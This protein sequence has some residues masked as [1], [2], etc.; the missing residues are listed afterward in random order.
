MAQTLIF[1]T[2][3]SKVVYSDSALQDKVA[4]WQI[5]DLDKAIDALGD[6]AAA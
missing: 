1:S 4:T 2:L 3:S 5:A 6:D